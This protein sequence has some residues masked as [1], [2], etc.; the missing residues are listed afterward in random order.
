[1]SF[2]SKDI[3]VKHIFKYC[4]VISE[5]AQEEKGETEEKSMITQKHTHNT[6]LMIV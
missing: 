2:F 1:M 5:I 6:R 3:I 4:G